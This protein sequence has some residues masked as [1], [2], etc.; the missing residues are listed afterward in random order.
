M[1]LIQIV[2]AILIIGVSLSGNIAF[3]Q[4]TIESRPPART[5]VGNP[6]PTPISIPGG[7]STPAPSID[8]TNLRQ[9]II[10]RFGITMNGYSNKHLQWAW[11]KFWN[12]SNTNFIPLVRGSRATAIS[13]DISRQLGC[14][15]NTK[16]LGGIIELSP[17]VNETV[18]KVILIHELGHVVYWCNEDPKTF[19]TEHVNALG[20]EG[21]VTGYGDKPCYGSSRVTEDYPETIAY[22]LS[23]G[24]PEQTPCNRRVGQIPYANGKFPLHY[25]VAR[26]IVGVF[27]F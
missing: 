23:P 20:V 1:K 16:G 6:S 11:E 25:N 26:S 5:M 19:R 15:N 14:V 2:T 17:Y 9:A 13:G 22:Y 27:L 4:D 12:V 7:A 21:G 24:V 8:P 10:D 18:F 3:A